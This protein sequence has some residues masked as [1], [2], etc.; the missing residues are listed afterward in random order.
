MNLLRMAI[1]SF[2]NHLKTCLDKKKVNRL[3]GREVIHGQKYLSFYFF[4][5]SLF[6]N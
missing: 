1:R 4:L 2:K 3:E 6:F 5:L